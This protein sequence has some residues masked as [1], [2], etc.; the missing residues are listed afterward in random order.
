MD[1]VSRRSIQ[2]V[3]SNGKGKWLGGVP[4]V[5]GV[6]IPSVETICPVR[7]T[8]EVKHQK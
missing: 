3:F 7:I 8:K 5:S 1:D 4:V 6:M 2:N